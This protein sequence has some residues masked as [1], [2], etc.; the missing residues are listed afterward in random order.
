MKNFFSY[1]PEEGFDLHESEEEAKAIAQGRI[2]SYR[3][4][5]VDGWPE[6]VEG[7][8]WGVVKQHSREF[9]IYDTACDFRLEDV[10]RK[11]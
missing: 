9:N 3:D 5:A 8:C 7:V 1:D 10:Y 4:D 2:D 11:T 6:A